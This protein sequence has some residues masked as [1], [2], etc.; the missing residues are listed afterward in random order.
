MAKGNVAKK[1]GT[2]MLE[3]EFDIQD[4]FQPHENDEAIADFMH[5]VIEASNN[6]MTLAVELTKLVVNKNTNNMNA[7]EVFS[8]FKKASDLIANSTPMKGLLEQLKAI[9]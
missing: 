5:G 7:E 1:R 9:S 6:Q 8:V 3:D 4:I 2:V